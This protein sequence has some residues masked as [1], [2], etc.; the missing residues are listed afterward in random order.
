MR[1]Y[2]N[3]L[4]RGTRP[5][6]LIE[7]AGLPVEIVVVDVMAGEQRGEAYKRLNPNG[8]VPVL[9]DGDQAIFESAAITLHLADKAPGLAPPVGTIERGLY[10]Q[11][12]FWAAVTLEVGVSE[13]FTERMKPEDQRDA[14][15]IAEGTRK[16]H[17]CLEILSRA[18]EGRE[19]LV[20][21]T[22]SAADILVISVLAW[23]GAMK[24]NEGFPTIEA[25]TARGKARP[26][27]QR[28]RS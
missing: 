18:L 19:W 20:A 11:W 10:Y 16:Y 26:A 1:L 27:F 5:R 2:F 23:A 24:M 3:K 17:A 8:K 25:Y 9:I 12:A 13:V 14:A 4:T 22:F 6:W 7:E 15:K 28:A 21:D